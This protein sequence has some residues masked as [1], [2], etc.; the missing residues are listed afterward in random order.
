MKITAEGTWV[1]P[2][3]LISTTDGLQHRWHGNV[4]AGKMPKKG[5]TSGQP[6]GHSRVSKQ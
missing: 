6:W 4:V 5:V 2:A 3:S 1:K